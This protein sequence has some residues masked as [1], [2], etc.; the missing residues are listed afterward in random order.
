MGEWGA[1]MMHTFAMAGPRSPWQVVFRD[2]LLRRLVLRFVLCRA[3]LSLHMSV[4]AEA[5]CAWAKAA[6]GGRIGRQHLSGRAAIAAVV[7]VVTSN[8]WQPFQQHPASPL[9]LR[10]R[11]STHVMCALMSHTHGAAALMPCVLP[12]LPPVACATARW[13]RT[14]PTCHA[15]SRS[16]HGRW[17]QTQQTS[18]QVGKCIRP[19][20]L[21]EV[22]CMRRCPSMSSFCP[23]CNHGCETSS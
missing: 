5:G 2:A 10:R 13:A 8:H 15:A 19:L 9:P 7:P 18:W 21:A 16:C 6:L 3:A 12:L 22:W 23:V 20:P 14:P 1:A 17:R 11:P 4:S